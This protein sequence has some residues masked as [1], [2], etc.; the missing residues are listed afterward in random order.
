MPSRSPW[1]RLVVK[2]AF[3]WA[4]MV[5][6]ACRKRWAK[7]KNPHAT[8]RFGRHVYVGPGFSL[9]APH[10]GTFEAGDGCEFRR[11]FRCELGAPDAVVRF[12]RQCVA[13]YDVL[14]QV[15]TSVEVGDRV[16]FGQAGAVFDGNHN[17][18]DPELPMMSQGYT[19]TPLSIGDDV[20]TLTKCTIV[21]DLGD[22]AVVAANTVVTKP[23]APY[24][25]VGGVPAKVIGT[26]GPAGAAR[27]EQ[28]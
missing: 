14:F 1:S 25:I 13:T 21:A 24:T 4:P 18:K 28:A 19:F 16:M 17:F 22:R 20:T 8:V 7:L 5:A 10:G 12:G 3:T 27:G 9:H 23:V 26:Y 11:G 2:V 15:T 6:S